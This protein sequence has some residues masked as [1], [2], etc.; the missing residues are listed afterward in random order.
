MRLYVLRVRTMAGF[1]SRPESLIPAIRNRA[2]RAMAIHGVAP[3]E[4]L[5]S[6][7]LLSMSVT[8]FDPFN[9]AINLA[10]ALVTPNAAV[11]VTG[12]SFV[13]QNGHAGTYSGFDFTYVA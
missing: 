12:A 4:A 8:P 2:S 7:R 10:N 5:E 13:G 3:V 9:P 6:R 1:F 11:N